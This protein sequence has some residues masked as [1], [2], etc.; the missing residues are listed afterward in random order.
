MLDLERISRSLTT[1][2]A[3]TTHKARFVAQE[4]SFT[5]EQANALGI[6]ELISEFTTYYPCCAP[7]VGNIQRGAE[8]MNGTIV[9]P[10]Q[11]FSLNEVL[12]K[13]TTERGFVGCAADLQR[14]AGGRGRR[15]RQPDRYDDVQRRVLRGGADRHPP[16]A[17]VLHL[18][19]SDGPR[20]DRLVGRARADLAQRLARGDPRRGPRRRG[21]DHG[22][23]LL[24]EAG[25][26]RRDDDRGA[27]AVHG[28]AHDHC[29]EPV[30]RARGRRTSCSRRGRRGS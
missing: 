27:D 3:S 2:L 5:T 22:A 23:A 15:G 14:P 20:G 19:V 16:A 30:A 6:H 21:F 9:R 8:I 24:V 18:A 11:R 17:R 10:G 4:P 12:G 13:R 1:N 7:R 26:P 29:L 25:T 28:A